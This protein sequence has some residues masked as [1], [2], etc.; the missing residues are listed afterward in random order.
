M[1]KTKPTFWT[2]YRNKAGKD[3]YL[4]KFDTILKAQNYTYTHG[5]HLLGDLRVVV[6]YD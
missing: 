4:A 2:V 3:L 5:F 6:V 1:K